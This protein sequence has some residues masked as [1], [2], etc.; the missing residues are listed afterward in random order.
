MPYQYRFGLAIA[1]TAAMVWC[2]GQPPAARAAPTPQRVDCPLSLPPGSVP[3]RTLPDGWHVVAPE[4]WSW[5]L[6]G[7]GMLHGAPDEGGYLVPT[8]AHNS[9]RRGRDISVR[10][11][12]MEVPHD[13]ETWLYCAYGPVQLARRISPT[14]TECIVTVEEKRGQRVS[15]AFV[16]R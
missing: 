11:W 14:A 12:T 6:D 7:S 10:R 1:T 9:K 8:S 16:C 15:T 2:L 13:H 3:A 4:A 5:K